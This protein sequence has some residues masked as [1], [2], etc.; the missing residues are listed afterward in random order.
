[1]VDST[2]DVGGYDGG[3]EQQG[4]GVNPSWQEYLNEIPQELHEKVIPAFEKWDK[5]VQD[6]FQ[7]VH[8]E[9]EPWKQFV[10]AGIEPNEVQFS[11]NLLNSINENP[12]MVWKA[13]GE[14]Y[15]LFEKETSNSGQGQGKPTG[16]E[17]VEDPYAPQFEELR[18][19]QQI[20][21]QV[22]LNQ[23]QAEL[24][25]QAD[26]DLDTELKALQGKH[27]DRG[28]F[29]ER[30]VLALMQNGFSSEDAVNAYFEFQEKE[31]QKFGVKPLIMG[32]GGGLPNPTTDVRKL[33]EAG[34]KNLV[35]QM[36]QGYAQQR[37]Q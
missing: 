12:E 10:D 4:T 30:Y 11:L 14:H 36:L 22:M 24:D 8:S 3:Q 19:Q 23:R 29:D 26:A 15:K 32:S 6:R 25:A 17:D 20:M 7:K 2:A 21:A 5:G 28:G 1:M 16:E 18:R 37:N 31:R 33:D 35:A 34:R 9:W 27:K 13:I